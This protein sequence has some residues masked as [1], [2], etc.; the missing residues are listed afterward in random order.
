VSEALRIGMP[1]EG[2]QEEIPDILKVRPITGGRYQPARV[3][4][5]RARIEEIEKTNPPGMQFIE[6]A[7]YALEMA[8]KIRPRYDIE[9][10]EPAVL[11]EAEARKTLE[12]EQIAHRMQYKVEEASAIAA[13]YSYG[14]LEQ[15]RALTADQTE[16]N[17]AALKAIGML[18]RKSL[19]GP[20]TKR[21]TE[22]ILRVMIADQRDMADQL[23]VPRPAIEPVQ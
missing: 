22:S 4:V 9:T 11:S 12:E 23:P 17:T 10:A 2:Y 8:G 14:E 13:T 6:L 18:D 15:L 1:F 5:Q 20:G 16:D 7:M 19:I 3:E 21:A